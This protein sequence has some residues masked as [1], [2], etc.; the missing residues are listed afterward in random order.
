MVTLYQLISQH[1]RSRLTGKTFCNWYIV[2]W[3]PNT[4]TLVK[5]FLGSYCT[6]LWK[7]QFFCNSGDLRFLQRTGQDGWIPRGNERG[8]QVNSHIIP[9]QLGSWWVLY[10]PHLASSHL[11]LLGLLPLPGTLN[12]CTIYPQVLHCILHGFSATMILVPHSEEALFAKKLWCWYFSSFLEEISA[13]K[14]GLV[15]FIRTKQGHPWWWR[16]L[17]IGW[18]FWSRSWWWWGDDVYDVRSRW[19]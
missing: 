4:Y 18:C 14:L 6:I 15:P 10:W 3:C 1:R 9:T 5:T 11:G 16:C 17:Q 19:W 8:E 7:R 13:F 12:R 2:K